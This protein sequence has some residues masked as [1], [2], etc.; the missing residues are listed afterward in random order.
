[1]ILKWSDF[2]RNHP[3]NEDYNKNIAA[4]QTHIPRTENERNSYR[5]LTD[6]K[7]IVCFT[8]GSLN[9]ELQ[10]TFNHSILKNSFTDKDAD[11]YALSGFGSRAIAVKVD[12][13]EI[14]KTTTQ[15]KKVP[16]LHDLIDC[17]TADEI[18]AV[19]CKDNGEKLIVTLSCH[20]S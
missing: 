15:K 4:L 17:E 5:H 8:K 20:L 9:N 16:S 19:E 12:P 13:V 6:N 18:K 1:M 11:C 14:F 10:V 2:L 7:F 3:T